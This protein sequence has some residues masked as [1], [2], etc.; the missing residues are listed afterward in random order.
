[1]KICRFNHDRIG[2]VQEDDVYDVTDLFER[3]LHWPAPLGDA[4]IGQ[5][6]KVLD[7]VREKLSGIQPLKLSSV[8]LESPVANPVRSSAHR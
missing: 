1:M 5:L 6:E 3:Q 4:V 8:R 7:V 2:V